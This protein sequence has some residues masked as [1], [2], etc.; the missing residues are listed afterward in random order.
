[1]ADIALQQP[2]EDIWRRQFAMETERHIRFAASHGYQ[3]LPITAPIEGYIVTKGKQI[4]A[5]CT[6]MMEA[7]EV[8]AALAYFHIHG[9]P[10]Y[11]S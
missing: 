6:L 9:R 1:M 4:L 8:A 5:R 10:S 2:Q 11:G 7:A 3:V